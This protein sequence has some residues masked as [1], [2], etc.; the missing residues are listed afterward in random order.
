MSN[1]A[2][3][4]RRRPEAANHVFEAHDQHDPTNISYFEAIRD[5]ADMGVVLMF[6]QDDRGRAGLA[7]IHQMMWIDAD[8]CE[9]FGKALVEA[10][11]IIRATAN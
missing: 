5:E 3:L 9:A 4:D 6:V 2:D 1:V 11:R 7:T 8:Q 10:A